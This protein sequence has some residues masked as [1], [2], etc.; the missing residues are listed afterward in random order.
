MP[1]DFWYYVVRPVWF[2]LCS[3]V[4][5]PHGAIRDLLASVDNLPPS[6]TIVRQR[7]E[8]GWQGKLV[9][10]WLLSS[11]NTGAAKFLGILSQCGS[12]NIQMSSMLSSIWKTIVLEKQ[13]TTPCE[14]F[15]EPTKNNVDIIC[16]SLSKVPPLILMAEISVLQRHSGISASTIATIT[17]AIAA[18]KTDDCFPA[19]SAIK[20]MVDDVVSSGQ[21]QCALFLNVLVFGATL[22]DFI[23]DQVTQLRRTVS[24]GIGTHSIHDLY[25][26][27]CVN[28]QLPSGI[29]TGQKN[30]T[31]SKKQ[32][33]KSGIAGWNAE[34]EQ[35]YQ[36]ALSEGQQIIPHARLLLCGPGRSGKSSV[37]RSLVDE[38]FEKISDSTI[39]VELQ[40][41]VCTIG[42][43]D[44][45]F[46]W[47]KE[48]DQKMQHL[49]MVL[50]SLNKA[51]QRKAIEDR[52]AQQH[53]VPV[54]ERIAAESSLEQRM[55]QPSTPSS[56]TTGVRS[57]EDSGHTAVVTN[58]TT[59]D[60]TAGDNVNAAVAKADSDSPSVDQTLVASCT[61]VPN[62]ADVTA[63]TSPD[64]K[65]N[66]TPETTTATIGNNSP[67]HD[68][69]DGAPPTIQATAPNSQ[70]RLSE[71]KALEIHEAE[72]S[73]ATPDS[74]YSPD[75]QSLE[76]ELSYAAMRVDQFIA[77][78]KYTDVS[79]YNIEDLRELVFLD[80]WDFAGQ[81]LFSALQHM[82][83]SSRRCAY[84]VVFDASKQ[85]EKVAEPTLCRGG[86]EYPLGNSQGSTNFDIMESWLNTIHHVIGNAPDVPVYAIGTHIDKLPRKTRQQSLDK[87][88]KF[89]WANAEERAYSRI[90]DEVVFVDNTVAGSKD[91]DETIIR[92]RQDFIEK[93][94]PQ[95]KQPIPIRWL[96]FTIG[97][98]EVAKKFKCPWLTI[99]QIYRLA[100]TVCGGDADNSHSQ[101]VDVEAM[102]KYQHHLGHIL[103]YPEN[104]I[105]SSKVIIDVE[106]LLRIA[107]LLFCPEPKSEQGKRLRPL[108][109]LLT[110][111]GILLEHLIIH[112]WRQHGKQTAMY[113]KTEEQRDYLYE[114]MEQS[115]LMYNTKTS[116]KIPDREEVSRKFYVPALVS[117]MPGDNADLLLDDSTPTI[118]LYTG[119]RR[120]LPQTLFW[121]AVVR[122]MQKYQP[123]QEPLLYQSAARLRCYGIYLL[124][125]EYFSHG[126][127]ISVAAEESAQSNIGSS[128]S[129]ARPADLPAMCSEALLFVEE[130]LEDLKKF[131]LQHVNISRAVRCKC[132]INQR[133]CQRHKK[134]SCPRTSC[135]HFAELVDGEVPLCPLESQPSVDAGPVLQY[136]KCIPFQYVQAG[137]PDNPVSAA[138]MTMSGLQLASTTGMATGSSGACGTDTDSKSLGAI[139]CKHLGNIDD[140]EDFTAALEPLLDDNARGKL[141]KVAVK[142]VDKNLKNNYRNVLDQFHE[143]N[144]RTITGSGHGVTSVFC[145]ILYLIKK[146]QELTIDELCA[147]LE[148]SAPENRNLI[149]P[150]L[151]EAEYTE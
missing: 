28:S 110:S 125:L 146:K 6:L 40:T 48:A 23:P 105:L 60:V 126:I 56:S 46:V 129:A 1:V 61:N 108:Y 9:I 12:E 66:T 8:T 25:I 55:A 95:F 20:A 136:F 35:A 43:R 97:T 128:Y 124:V 53:A 83:L 16:H 30:A 117:R 79:E 149:R 69:A 145:I 41:A 2:D 68:A 57:A 49:L 134:K 77:D 19:R 141:G 142:L 111:K 118:Y 86:E 13:Q 37:E 127:R 89:I 94:E 15:R 38:P 58:D 144:Q 91:P 7:P 93:L 151:L 63:D 85:M 27:V 65:A 74:P 139:G 50:I 135:H 121:C 116:M 106:W 140:W 42:Q 132:P 147:Q 59:H 112:R 101:P 78:L 31:S 119:S 14:F 113:T 32:T 18:C 98:K 82:V 130:Q 71:E 73:C 104:R 52:L 114:L 81:K 36:L 29:V 150:A 11:G 54:T 137:Q 123:R 47:R 96:P 100:N 80:I 75:L 115:G 87:M 99:E 92:L 34:D 67:I 76:E 88:K 109:E 64:A 51:V 90:L 102:L 122:C 72:G 17:A 143:M 62:E 70:P 3:N 120:Y 24:A 148:D 138:L 5:L 10:P 45:K 33:A 26:A 133:P 4:K 44:G 22:D 131:G 84:A 107:S 103:Y 39:G 21:A